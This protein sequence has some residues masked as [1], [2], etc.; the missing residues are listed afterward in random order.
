MAV[1]ST[2]HRIT[3]TVDDETCMKILE[4]A[5]ANDISMSKAA[6]RLIADGVENQAELDRLRVDYDDAKLGLFDRI[7]RDIKYEMEL[8]AGAGTD[9]VEGWHRGAI[10]ALQGI[11]DYMI[12]WYSVSA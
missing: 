10:R 3:V 1:K 2:N 4:Y 9:Y 7:N 12:G 5:E 6:A 8:E 11:K